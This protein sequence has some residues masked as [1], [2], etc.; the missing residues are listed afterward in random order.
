MGQVLAIDLDVEGFQGQGAGAALLHGQAGVVDDVEQ[1]RLQLDRIEP[2]IPQRRCRAEDE[3]EG[4]AQGLGQA[5]LAGIDELVQVHR[6]PGQAL[7]AGEGQQLL[8]EGRRPIH[9]VAGVVDM[10]LGLVPVQFRAVQVDPQDIQVADHHL[11]QVVEIVGDA[12][13]ELTQGFHL[14]RL[15]QGVFGVAAAGDVQLRGE[16][17]A[18]LARGIEHRRD[19]QRIPEGRAVLAVIQ[20]LDVA[21]ALLA[22]GVADL[23]DVL[24]AS[25]GSLQ[26]AAIAT[27]H[28]VQGITCG[29]QE[30]LVGKDDR[31]IRLV[32]IRHDHRHPG[33]LHGG[34]ED[35]VVAETLAQL[36]DLGRGGVGRRSVCGFGHG[37]EACERTA[38]PLL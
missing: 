20:Q 7:L 6:A 31:V 17:I 29:T 21:V 14:L 18:Q 25:V 4:A 24:L 33:L 15:A 36:R 2:A 12:A 22:D 38:I 32:R 23:G 19:E 34:K 28:L 10:A 27:Q 37:E 16:E 9:R 5:T 13:G 8:G 26:E 35:V 1:R 3:A 11:Q 30:G